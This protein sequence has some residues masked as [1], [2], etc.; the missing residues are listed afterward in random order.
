MLGH[1]K[2]S[3]FAFADWNLHRND[4][5]S[6]V[7]RPSLWTLVR[8]FAWTFVAVILLLATQYGYREMS[9]RLSTSD[10]T[11]SAPNNLAEA[12]SID[13]MVEDAR[14]SLRATMTDSEWRDYEARESAN[15]AH[16]QA[17]IDAALAERAQMMEIVRY[18]ALALTAA[19]AALAIL[20]PFLALIEQ[21]TVAR[22]MRGN[23]VVTRRRLLS[24]ATVCPAS[25]L[26]PFRVLVQGQL[27]RNRRP[28]YQW[29]VTTESDVA[30]G[31][32]G[33]AFAFYVDHSNHPPM[34]DQRLP[35]RVALFVDGMQRLT[36]LPH[37]GPI[38]LESSTPQRS[39]FRVQT[40]INLD[41]GPSTRRQTF[42]SIDELP[43]ELRGTIEA[44]MAQ[45]G[46]RP[47]RTIEHRVVTT[48][49]ITVEDADGNVRTF[50][51]PDEMPPDMRA[52]FEEMRRQH[53]SNLQ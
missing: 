7:Y 17:R 15:R 11:R 5:T 31:G 46:S 47:D 40:T 20:P 3:A 37:E 23:F 16:N 53:G 42:S 14:A 4:E 51:S 24:R 27:F 49:H 32:T 9:G 30:R 21:I 26:T 35:E 50:A 19:L 41:S 8:R 38:V 33:D 25:T 43:P 22:D 10:D 13:Q 29:I 28:G 45:T 12:E 2:R 1:G 39:P 6:L 52:I 44:M 18:A 36:G 34:P 48:Q